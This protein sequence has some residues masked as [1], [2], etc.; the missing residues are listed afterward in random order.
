MTYDDM[1]TDTVIANGTFTIGTNGTYTLTADGAT[2]TTTLT[3]DKTAGTA[4]WGELELLDKIL[5]DREFDGKF[6][7]TAVGGPMAEQLGVLA[8]AELDIKLSCDA[9]AG[10]Y[11]VVMSGTL[12]GG[13]VTIDDTEL[14]TGTYTE[15]TDP[16]Y[17]N[18]VPSF[19]FATEK[20]GAAVSVESTVD[21]ATY[22]AT[23]TVTVDLTEAEVTLNAM[24]M[25]APATL[26]GSGTATFS[27]TV[28]G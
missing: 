10:T 6:T 25:Q 7:I 27:F 21:T 5:S 14:V 26:T 28:G 20:T 3:V 9:V 1:I 24:G 18:M 4:V 2:E 23:Y 11:S 19:T 12:M 8:N 13:A 17:G 15:G 22:T 16:A